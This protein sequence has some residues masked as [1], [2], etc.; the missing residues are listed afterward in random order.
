MHPDIEYRMITTA[1]DM[2]EIEELQ[3]TV[4]GGATATPVPQ[5]VASVQNG[6][7]VI[8]A[9]ING[10]CAGFCFG[11]AGFKQ[12][13]TY[14][15]SHMLGILP[16]YRDLGLGKRLKLEQRNWALAN[17]YSKMMWTYDPLEARN[18][19]LNLCKLGGRVRTYI[20]SYYGE[21]KDGI[22][23]GLPTDRFLL[24]WDLR[25]ERASRAAE[26]DH[27]MET[28]WREYPL[29]LDWEEVDSFPVPT[30]QHSLERTQ[31]YLIPVPAAIHDLKREQSAVALQW[32]LALRELFQS[33]FANGYEA[34][35]LLKSDEKVHFYVIE[36]SQ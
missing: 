27:L 26:G 25:S 18:A 3:R 19:Y 21:M 24:E 34:V 13:E 10:K 16:E 29:L 2:H 28:K 35:G 8:G 17:G 9:Y 5:L 6:G 31:G 30:V 11:F 23:K 32:R 20:E 33:A 12:G 14:L 15:L 22:N 1:H 7:V 36:A 4:W